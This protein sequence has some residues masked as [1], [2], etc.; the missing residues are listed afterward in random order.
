MTWLILRRLLAELRIGAFLLA[1]G[2]SRRFGDAD[3]LA[4]PFRGRMLGEHA[5]AAMPVEHFAA[6]GA[7]VIASHVGH[8]CEPAWRNA[9]FD[10]ALN[11]LA[12]EGMGTSVSAA[13]GIASRANFDAILIALADMPL[14]PREH[15]AALIGAMSG[16][17]DIICSTGGQSPMPPAIFGSDHFGALAKLSGDTGARG[18][19][20]KGRAITCPA[21]WLIDIDTPE[22]LRSLDTGDGHARPPTSTPAFKPGSKGDEF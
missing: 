20:A 19:L 16:P 12:G 14:V 10:I 4:Q 22:I 18:T 17:A 2:S 9:G 5:A 8:P 1:A 21:G 7:W 3:K 11:Q 6:G 13:A 15:F